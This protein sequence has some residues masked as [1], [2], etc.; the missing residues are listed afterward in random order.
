VGISSLCSSWNPCN[1]WCRQIVDDPGAVSPTG[2]IVYEPE[3]GGLTLERQRWAD[4]LASCSELR[5]TPSAPTLRV[6]AL[7]ST[8]PVEVEL[9][10]EL[11]PEGCSGGASPPL[12]WSLDPFEFAT[13]T[14]AGKL[15]LVTPVA[16]PIAVTAYAGALVG[17]TTVEVRVEA[18]DLSLAPDGTADQ[19]SGSGSLPDAAEL[20]YPYRGV[21]FPLGL[22]AP[23]VQWDTHGLAAQAIKL[24]LRKTTPSGAPFS[25][26][27]I[28]PEMHELLLAPPAAL[29]S[30]SGPRAVIPEEVWRL[31]E[32]S[33]RGSEAEIVIQRLTQ[34]ALRR[35]L[36]LPMAFADGPLRGTLYYQSLGTR[37]V[38][39]S[40]PIAE[41]E[42]GRFGA[43]TLA[44]PLG[45]ARP[46]VAAGFTSP[47]YPSPDGK[48]CRLCHSVA[49]QGSLLITNRYLNSANTADQ[50]DSLL[51]ELATS[52]PSG[53]QPFPAPTPNGGLY[54]FGAIHP[55]GTLLFGS[56]GPPAAVEMT[57]V[58]GGLEGSAGD[59]PSR[60]YSLR[61]D[62]LGEVVEPSGLPA[63]L[64]AALPSFSPEGIR[65][66]FT[67]YGGTVDGVE[68]DRRS[69]G[70]LTFAPEELR[71]FGF[72]RLFTEPSEPCSAEFGSD[73]P[74]TSVWPSFLPL[75]TGVVFEREVLNNGRVPGAERADFGGTRA[76]C[77]A[78]ED[79]DCDDQGSRGEL[80]WV[81]LQGSAARLSAANGR[82]AAGRVTLP[83]G[84]DGHDAV[85][86]ALL[87]Y[88]PLASP[89]AMGG[90][91]WVAFTSRR[92]YGNVARLNPWW[93]DPRHQRLAGEDGVT[94]KKLWMAAIDPS[95]QPGTDPSR[96]AFYLPGQ[97]L[98]AANSRAAW[99]L[100]TCR[101]PFLER[102]SENQCTTDADCCGA[103][104]EARCA[105]DFPLL[106]PPI[107]HCIPVSP[108]VCIED[109]SLLPCAN[110]GDCCGAAN[111]SRCASGTCRSLP[112]LEVYLPGQVVRDFVAECPRDTE[113]VWRELQFQADT[114]E[115]TRVEFWVQSAAQET[116]LDTAEPPMLLLELPGFYAPGQWRI[117]ANPVDRVLRMGNI[118]PGPFL[119]LIMRLVPSSDQRSAPT[120]LAWRQLYDCIDAR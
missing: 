116:E 95:A 67:H 41:L 44:L 59:V 45:Q 33:A 79:S 36:P 27:T 13:I 77:A 40:G 23:L 118:V 69:L 106:A 117:S 84:T 112:E 94:T 18:T 65:V 71:F 10:A 114:P 93:S 120:L 14:E 30:L 88:Q 7:P 99:A 92:L 31:F 28:L 62:R 48:G 24:T 63:E 66:V 42:S 57:P 15:T 113:P 73:D 46:S 1:P 115:G 90:Y 50:G 9:L 26:S 86:E 96:P 68:G 5:I 11:L 39:N 3:T 53:G 4:V 85:N 29:P 56:A 17:T 38:E 119:R 72:Q 12:L 16:G 110:D 32:R 103:P 83:T 87:N 34:G 102:S 19:F 111:G 108:G 35:E 37:L 105:V 47:G 97:E 101:E 58:P 55:G 109:G 6:I 70:V 76:G 98:L 8:Q 80:W 100:P 25:W 52:T 75:D 82:D 2:S 104:A 78:S 74:C 60:L 20:L 89:A 51:F 21:V 107:R 22:P 61:P 64:R 91:Y 54:G 43:A 49:A 81:T